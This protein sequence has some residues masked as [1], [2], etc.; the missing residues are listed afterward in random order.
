MLAT[1]LDIV[2]DVTKVERADLRPNDVVSQVGI[3]SL[4]ISQ[5]L[6]ETEIELAV[7]FDYD[8]LPDDWSALTLEE[9]AQA[10]VGSI[11]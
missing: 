10:M 5:V 6:V 9:L 8:Q 7:E 11:L 4:G 2:A 1:L 3:D